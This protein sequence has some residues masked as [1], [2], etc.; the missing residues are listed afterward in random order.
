[1]DS[2]AGGRRDPGS[3]CSHGAAFGRA[4]LSHSHPPGTPVTKPLPDGPESGKGGPLRQSALPAFGEESENGSG[5]GLA[6]KEDR[7]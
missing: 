2:G 5:P 6:G 4:H 1:M 7:A 3:G